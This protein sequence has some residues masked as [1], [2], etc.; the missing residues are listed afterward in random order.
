MI[1]NEIIEIFNEIDNS[2]INI[3][4]SVFFKNDKEQTEF[5]VIAIEIYLKDFYFVLQNKDIVLR[6]K[7]YQLTKDKLGLQ[8]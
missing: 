4:D 7:N 1:S 3:T 8:A 2:G 5:I 6:A